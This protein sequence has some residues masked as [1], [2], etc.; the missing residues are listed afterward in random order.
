MAKAGEAVVG[1]LLGAA[2]PLHPTKLT[3]AEQ[4]WLA[5]SNPN[6]ETPSP[7]ATHFEKPQLF[8]MDQY[9]GLVVEA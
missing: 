8:Q 2:G 1:Y 4:G 9:L 7:G 5:A 6:Q 3:S